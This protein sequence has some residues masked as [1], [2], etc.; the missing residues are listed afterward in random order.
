MLAL[1]DR[2]SRLRILY[3][4]G[5]TWILFDIFQ[6]D[7][8][9]E[10]KRLKEQKH[11]QEKESVEVMV[12]EVEEYSS[13]TSDINLDTLHQ[14]LILLDEKARKSCDQ[15]AEEYGFILQRFLANKHNP[16]VG[17]LIVFMLSSKKE[18]QLMEKEQKFIKAW[19]DQPSKQRF[20]KPRFIPQSPKIICYKCGEM[21]HVV[22]KCNK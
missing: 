18:Y 4:I 1:A 9:Q 12:R 3:Q 6:F 15:S 14:K 7:A 20:H 19:G 22:A 21:G 17:S 5:K 8:R 16:N 10:I 13:R 2:S 11:K